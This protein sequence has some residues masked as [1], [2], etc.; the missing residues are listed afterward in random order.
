MGEVYLAEDT[1]LDRQVALKVLSPL[2]ASDPQYVQ[3]FR[4]EARAASSLSHPQVCVIH[5]V[6]EAEDGCPFMAMELVEGESLDARLLRGP[7]P[8]ADIVDIRLQVAEALDAAHSKGIV[9]RDAKP[10]NV[11]VGSGS[12]VKAEKLVSLGAKNVL[13][14]G[15]HLEG[16]AVDVLFEPEHGFHEFTGPRIV[17][18]HTHGTGCTYSAAIT[19]ELAK[20]T[21]LLAAIGRAKEFITKAILSAPGLGSG[22]GPLNHHA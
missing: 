22:T 6:G 14:K 4:R 18:A 10:A 21:A 8:M 5:E 1:S 12:R 9:H 17:T 15:G 2:L 20:G 3:R 16:D 11:V 7:P 19:A 13:V